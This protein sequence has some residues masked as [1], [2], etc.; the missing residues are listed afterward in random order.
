M[1]DEDR[2]TKRGHARSKKPNA[3][4]AARIGQ[5]P[6]VVHG[7]RES[8]DEHTE[9]GDHAIQFL[10]DTPTPRTLDETPQPHTLDDLPP[11]RHADGT[12][13][14]MSLD[15]V[16]IQ[17]LGGSLDDTDETLI[18]SY[19]PI[20]VDRDR[21]TSDDFED[22]GSTEDE[23]ATF[24]YEMSLEISFDPEEEERSLDEEASL[25]GQEYSPPLT[26]PPDKA[27]HRQVLAKTVVHNMGR[28]LRRLGMVGRQFRE[29][30][31]TY[32]RERDRTE[33]S[34]TYFCSRGEPFVVAVALRYRSSFLSAVDV[35]CLFE[36]PRI[37]HDLGVP[38]GTTAYRSVRRAQGTYALL[39]GYT[40]EI[41]QLGTVTGVGSFVQR[42]IT[43]YVVD[44]Y[45]FAMAQGLDFGQLS[46]ATL[47]DPQY[48][49]GDPH[50]P[51]ARLD[52][53]A[54][55]AADT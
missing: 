18:P 40:P 7:G 27:L 9:L 50:A 17:S 47:A 52:A 29:L 35:R 54:R 6:L 39:Y 36:C 15:D 24:V 42:G 46:G 14:P 11:P 21:L 53:F 51:M 22:R 28:H 10:D 33:V 23:S 13:V 45:S 26:L 34:T 32:Y 20:E 44:C 30:V 55:V 5:D 8:L 49:V 1:S 16:A 38:P 3:E 41:R 37:S 2:P 25:G 4:P 19:D 43:Q 12:P 48:D 31:S